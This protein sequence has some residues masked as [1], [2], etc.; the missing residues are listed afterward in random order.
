MII[1][2]EQWKNHFMRNQSRKA[3][4]VEACDM[5]AFKQST[6][7]AASLAIF[8]LGEA[9]EGRIAHQI[10]SCDLEGIDDD[11]RKALKLF[12][13]EEGGHAKLLGQCVRELGGKILHKNWT[14][15]LFVFGRRLL[16]IRLKLLVLL[17]AEVIGLCFYD[18]LA[19]KIPHA[20]I[21]ACLRHICL[22]EKDHLEFHSD[23]FKTQ[24]TNVFKKVVFQFLWR[25]VGSL[26]ALAV[27]LDHRKTL[28]AL[29]IPVLMVWCTF[30]SWIQTAEERVLAKSLGSPNQKKGQLLN[31]E[32]RGC[33]S[34]YAHDE[35]ERLLGRS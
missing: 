4:V 5:G 15:R 1:H 6:E 35:G 26:A 32:V 19:D 34:G 22:D 31:P 17:S 2:W 8:Q 33:R 11:Y 30:Q 13:K 25:L 14:E 28:R 3:F 9:G 23:F 29:D 21:Q 10:D 24:T 27:I 7:V 12:V 16:G 20:S 18:L